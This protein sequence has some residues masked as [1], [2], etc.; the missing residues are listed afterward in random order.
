VA[1]VA[2]LGMAFTVWMAVE[3]VR[4]GHASGWL[5]IILLFGP[6]G[7]AVYFFAEYADGIGIFRG[8]AFG[9]RA[10]TVADVRAAEAEVR[11]LG[12]VSTWTSYAAALRGRR[13]FAKAADAATKALEH[14]PASPDARYELGLALEGAGRWEEARAELERVV[15]AD[16]SFD[17]DNALFALARTEEACGRDAEARVAL[18]ELARRSARP[19]VLYEC[20]AVQARQ[21]DRAAAAENLHRIIAEAETVPHYLQRSVRPWVRKAKQALRKMGA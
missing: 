7:A 12:N 19:E 14:D 8:P 10:V 4:R 21:G 15:A 2:L 17:S 11:R 18:E 1:F 3:A 20:A 13:D 5:W 9:P 6:L 16:R